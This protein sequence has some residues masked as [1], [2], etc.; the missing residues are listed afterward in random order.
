MR[1]R[2]A[3]GCIIVWGN[4]FIIINKIA[5][6]DIQTQEC[7]PEWDFVKGGVKSGEKNVDAVLRELKEETGS[8]SYRILYPL[9][10]KLLFD[11]KQSGSKGK[12]VYDN[13]ETSFYLAEFLG[14]FQELQADGKEI[15]AI[16]CCTAKEVLELLSHEETKQYFSAFL[17]EYE[18]CS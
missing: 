10:Q 7:C 9:P 11:F 12:S 6:A 14:K 16:K 15:G 13:Q 18:S 3:V 4:K 2:K 5:N 1:T 17:S 8:D